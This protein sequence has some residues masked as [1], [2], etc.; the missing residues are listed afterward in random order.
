MCCLSPT[1]LHPQ[2]KNIKE[3]EF[4]AIG[5]MLAQMSWELPQ[6]EEYKSDSAQPEFLTQALA[7]PPSSSGHLALPCAKPDPNSPATPEQWAKVQK[8]VV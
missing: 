1:V 6:V 7:A 4:T 8:M 2:G 3:D 5:D